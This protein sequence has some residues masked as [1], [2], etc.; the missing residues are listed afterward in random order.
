V[1]WLHHRLCRS[2]RWRKTIRQ[3][4]PWALS[5]SELGQNILELG[6]GPGLTTDLVRQITQRLTAIEVDPKLAAG[7]R[8]RL[9][10]TNVEVVTG[11]ATAMPFADGQ[12]SGS[13]S[14]SMLHHVPSPELQDKLLHEV[15]RV[16]E[17]GGF[18]VGADSWGSFLMMR[19]IHLGDTLVPVDPDT[20]GA[21]LEAAGFKVLEIEKNSGAFRF[22][23]RRLEIHASRL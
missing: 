10:G 9:R 19:L 17:P 13:V 23:A 16:V 4:V 18:F 21:R 15:W 6:P 3:R 7:L 20:F 22:C 2:G 5:G 14:F 12:F 11:D 1:N 8:S